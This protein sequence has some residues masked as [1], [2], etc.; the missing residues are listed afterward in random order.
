MVNNF[1]QHIVFGPGL[2]GR[3]NTLAVNWKHV[4]SAKIWPKYA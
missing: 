2:W 1:E 3:N 4:F